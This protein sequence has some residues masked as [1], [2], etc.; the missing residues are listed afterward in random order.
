MF[1]VFFLR[2]SLPPILSTL[3]EAAYTYNAKK[4]RS[5]LNKQLAK[6]LERESYD[7]DHGGL[8]LGPFGGYEFDEESN[9]LIIPPQYQGDRKRSSVFRERSGNLYGKLLTCK[10]AQ[11]DMDSNNFIIKENI[12]H[13]AITN[14]H[15]TSERIGLYI[16]LKPLTR[17]FHQKLFLNENGCVRL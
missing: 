6:Y 9:K 14:D 17:Q 10:Q 2:F 7:A 8:T 5:R 11:P 15:Q 13:L 3:I 12:K 16:R 1:F 4:P